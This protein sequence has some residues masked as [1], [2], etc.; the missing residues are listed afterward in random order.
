VIQQNKSLKNID[1][2]WNTLGLQGGRLLLNV[3]RDNKTI[4]DLILRGNCIPEDIA[5]EMEERLRENRR[6]CVANEFVLSSGDMD[7]ARF[8]STAEKQDLI[9]PTMNADAYAAII[10]STPENALRKEKGLKSLQEFRDAVQIDDQINTSIETRSDA[11]AGLNNQRCKRISTENRDDETDETNARIADLGEILRERSATI[12]L[13]TDKLATKVTEVNDTRA[14]LSLLQTEI[15]QLQEEKEKFDSNKAEEIARLQ[16]NHD[17]A[18]ESW[19][20]SY[21]D[22]KNNY[23]ECSQNKKEADSKVKLELCRSS[24]KQET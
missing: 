24:R 2:S 6:R 8:S 1:L 19:R 23:N 12:D 14:Q 7:N 20:K 11:N 10:N 13:L 18:E 16:K 15:H 5:L 4:T 9:R 21:K 3:M 22:L 17:E